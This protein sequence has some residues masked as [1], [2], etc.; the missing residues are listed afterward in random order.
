MLPSIELTSGK[1]WEAQRTRPC[2]GPEDEKE[3]KVRVPTSPTE[4]EED[5]SIY[6]KTVAQR[7]VVFLV[8]VVQKTHRVLVVDG[9]P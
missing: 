8:G 9:G 2:A 3:G 4:E 1:V 7:G 5:F 6:R